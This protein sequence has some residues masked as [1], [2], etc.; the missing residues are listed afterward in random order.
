[1]VHKV[2]VGMV[3]VVVDMVLVHKAEGMEQVAHI[4]QVAHMEQVVR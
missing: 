3:V 2:V 4:E 1:M